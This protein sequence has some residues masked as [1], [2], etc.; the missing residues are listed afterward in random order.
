MDSL[1]DNQESDVTDFFWLVQ[2]KEGP[3]S[4]MTE[5]C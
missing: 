4:H 3:I 2:M 5:F 1:M